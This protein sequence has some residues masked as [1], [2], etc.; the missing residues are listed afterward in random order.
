MC[1]CVNAQ[2]HYRLEVSADNKDREEESSQMWQFKVIKNNVSTRERWKRDS[3]VAFSDQYPFSVLEQ[4]RYMS[5]DNL[6]SLP[7]P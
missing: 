3:V 4:R 6:R 2:Y 1:E 7:I 5:L